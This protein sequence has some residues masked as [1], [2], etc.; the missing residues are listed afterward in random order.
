MHK[1]VLVVMNQTELPHFQRRD[2]L[3]IL[4][5]NVPGVGLHLNLIYA[6]YHCYCFNTNEFVIITH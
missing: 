3:F 6:F 1:A 2:V 5:I 4:C